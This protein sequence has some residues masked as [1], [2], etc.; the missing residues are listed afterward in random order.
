MYSRKQERAAWH[1]LSPCLSKYAAESDRCL[2][3]PPHR[4]FT[5]SFKSFRPSFL[6]SFCVL[7]DFVIKMSVVPFGKKVCGLCQKTSGILTCDGCQQAFC[8]KHVIEH[9]Q[10]LAF[11]L[12]N[13]M[14][15]H[16]CIQHDIN[17]NM[18]SHAPLQ[19]I[20]EWEKEA[21]RKIHEVANKVR[22]NWQNICESSSKQLCDRSR[23]IAD[24]LR[25]AR[26][27]E[28]FF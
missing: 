27:A 10:Q 5:P 22:A 25:T 19:Q 28:D 2:H 23:N 13:I 9:R 6:S 20:D 12:E 4:H 21:I 14:Q 15:E 11:Q 24:K 26:E 8:G 18:N 7:D 16:D 3:P 17:L 1:Q